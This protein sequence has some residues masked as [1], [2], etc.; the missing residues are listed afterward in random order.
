MNENCVVLLLLC[1]GRPS[2]W[3][4]QG[5]KI[6]LVKWGIL[7]DAILCV[8]LVKMGIMKDALRIVC[9]YAKQIMQAKISTHPTKSGTS[10][11]LS[12]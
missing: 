5:E 10:H 3:L 11:G 7:E 6:M 2:L 9:S 4:G 8:V 12:W 1:V